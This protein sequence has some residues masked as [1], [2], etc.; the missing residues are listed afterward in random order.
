[1][2]RCTGLWL[3]VLRQRQIVLRACPSPSP[4]QTL[5]LFSDIFT[6]SFLSQKKLE[7]TKRETF[8][9]VEFF[10]FF[11]DFDLPGDFCLLTFAAIIS[12]IF[13]LS[14]GFCTRTRRGELFSC[15]VMVYSRSIGQ[16][17]VQR[18]REACLGCLA[19]EGSG[20]Q[21]ESRVPRFSRARKD[22][23]PL[24][25]H[26]HPPSFSFRRSDGLD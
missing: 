3:A 6:I 14:D 13:S 1:M 24:K 7:T 25:R 22:S 16:L 12:L 11:L 8:S 2:P 21:P 5:S 10:L 9:S 26:C 19:A 18:S 17:V 4:S 15:A 23:S 20:L